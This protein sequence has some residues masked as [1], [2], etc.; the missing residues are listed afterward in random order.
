MLLKAVP[1]FVAVGAA[2]YAEN[3]EPVRFEELM[4]R[5]RQ[6]LDEGRFEAFRAE[7]SEK[8]GRPAP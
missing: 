5:I 1:L 4:A 6:A 7:Y 2:C 3:T 8:L